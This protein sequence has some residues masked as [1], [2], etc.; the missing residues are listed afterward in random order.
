MQHFLFLRELLISLC[1][2]LFSWFFQGNFILDLELLNS[3]SQTSDD[4]FGLIFWFCKILYLLFPF[5]TLTS[6]NFKILLP[7]LNLFLQYIIFLNNFLYIIDFLSKI[8][9]QFCYLCSFNKQLLLNFWLKWMQL[10]KLWSK[11]PRSLRGDNSWDF[12]IERIRLCHGNGFI[13]II[14]TPFVV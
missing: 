9:L 8:V 11:L 1:T 14:W 12:M 4:F 5:D 6:S 13:I 2:F 10:F 7:L 3:L